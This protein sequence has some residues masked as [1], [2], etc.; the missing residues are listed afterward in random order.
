[1][2]SKPIK[3]ARSTQV[4]RDTRQFMALGAI[5]GNRSYL[6]DSGGTESHALHGLGVIEGNRTHPFNS[7][8]TESQAL[9][10]L[11]CDRR[12]SNSL[13][14]CRTSGTSWPWVRSTSTDLICSTRVARNPSHFM[15]LG[16]IEAN[17]TRPFD[18]GGAGP[19]ALH[20]LGCDRRQSISSVR[21][22]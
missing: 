13:R 20:G 3:L 7:G 10:D 1:M 12:Q 5:E 19:Q 22:G 6:F 17:R 14:W 16:A 18:S 2:R 8:G 4:V 11:G 15:A 9:H 21:L